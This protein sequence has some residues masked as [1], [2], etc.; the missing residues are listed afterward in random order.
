MD[1][2]PIIDPFDTA[3]VHEELARL[4]AR[5]EA[6]EPL[7]AVRDELLRRLWPWALAHARRVA[8]RTP[9]RADRAEVHSQVLVAVWQACERF[10]PDRWA[11][12]PALLRTRVAGAR[13]DA[14]RRDDLLTRGDRQALREAETDTGDRATAARLARNAEWST[15]ED[16]DGPDDRWEPQ[17]VLT[18]AEQRSVVT[19]WVHNDLPTPLARR[20]QSWSRRATPGASMPAGLVE[21]LLPYLSRLVCYV[22][23][24]PG[25]ATSGWGAGIFPSSSSTTTA[26]L[27][28]SRTAPAA[29]PRG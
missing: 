6:G 4:A 29:G 10:E 18:E 21:G 9:P 11:T 3:A 27:S 20:V 12:W 7:S 24:R 8:A 5:T 2:D 14:A 17:R 23:D 26:S 25:G 19:S 1:V 16:W 15:L 22:E 13:A 28:S